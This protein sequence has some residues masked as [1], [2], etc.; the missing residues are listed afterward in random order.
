MAEVLIFDDD[1]SVGDLMSEIL[2]GRGLTVAHFLTGAGALQ[3]VQENK[4]KLVVLDIMMPGMDGLTACR[5]LKSNLATKHIK[6]AVLTAKDFGQDRATA[7]RYGADLFLNKPFDPGGF[8]RSILRMLGLPD[9]AA[10][11]QA[12]LPP[13]IATM[14]PGA[15]IV[16][17][18]DLWV[19][20]DA[21]A[22]L[23]GWIERQQ[24]APMISWL[25]LSRYE[26]APLSELAGA[27]L[28][29]AAGSRLNLAGPDDA[30]AQLPKLAPKLCSDAKTGRLMP[31]IYPQ[32]EGEFIL[33]AGVRGVTKLTQHPGTCMAY[34]I[35]LLG[36]SLVYCP[37]HEINPDA[38]QWNKHERSKFRDFFA[39]A[40]LLL[41]GYWRS[42]AEPVVTAHGGRG[43][44]EPV[45][46]LAAEA[47]VKRL[48]LLPYGP[49]G[50]SDG[51]SF[52]LDERLAATH[53]S[54][55]CA[56][57]PFFERVIL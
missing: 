11:P 6:V 51:I 10:A 43:A 48:A 9:A 29:M 18:P 47:G 34:R 5:T 22:G 41:H 30:E 36:K 38:A 15:I 56:V 19:F 7:V 27:G 39:G 52:R 2:R 20:C 55:R 1:P 54:L 12:P 13:V 44:W 4:P 25:L 26:P 42:A 37:A 53:S 16:E 31:L 17:A 32:R 46:D 40:D 49:A 35:E 45:I 21:G 28:V 3:I 57:T 23:R 8:A 50:A 14:L 24:R 33:A